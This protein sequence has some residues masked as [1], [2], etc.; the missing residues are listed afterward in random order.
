MKL[1]VRQCALV[2]AML[3]ATSIWASDYALAAKRLALVVG[4]SKYPDWPLINPVNDAR[5]IAK[6]LAQLDFDVTT[7]FE[8]ERDNI[9]LVTEAFLKKVAPE[10]TVVFFYAGHG[11]QVAGQN[12]LLATDARIRTQFDVHRN[13]IDFSRFLQRLDATRASVKLVFLDACRNN[14]FADKFRGGDSRGLARIGGAPFGTIISFATQPGG[15]AAD[16]NG[17]HGVYTAALLEHIDE[18][19][20]PV[21]QML[22]RVAVS[23]HRASGGK[24]R[25]W[26]E[27]SLYGDF[28]FKESSSGVTARNKE[29]AIEPTEDYSSLAWKIATDSN[30]VGGYQAFLQEFPNSPYA[31]LARVKIAVLNGQKN[32]GTA[33]ADTPKLA[34]LSTAQTKPKVQPAAKSELAPNAIAKTRLADQ[35]LIQLEGKIIRSVSNDDYE[36]EFR[37]TDGQLVVSKMIWRAMPPDAEDYNTESLS[38]GL[39]SNTIS[40]SDTGGLFGNCGARNVAVS[41]TGTLDQIELNTTYLA[42]GGR[43]S[44][45]RAHVKMQ[46]AQ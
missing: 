15:I 45:G 44:G 19:G 6:K 2:M 39:F 17:Q 30:D 22:K 4:N 28:H 38:C 31:R 8:L 46:L 13:G 12:F 21:E 25:P 37:V 16:G 18:P 23:T 33:A 34:S 1:F 3:I 32:A 35:N 20:L 26:V 27:G 14:P 7:E 5:A 41:I 40:V 43:T 24:Q 9:G 42:A 36:L 11:V 29:R 10:D